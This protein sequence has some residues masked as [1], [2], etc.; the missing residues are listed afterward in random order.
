MAHEKSASLI[1]ETLI[2]ID[3]VDPDSLYRRWAPDSRRISTLH[4]ETPF[5]RWQPMALMTSTGR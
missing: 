3:G 1:R 2:Q 5:A 4:A